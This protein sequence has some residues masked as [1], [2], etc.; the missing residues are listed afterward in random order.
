MSL[1][2]FGKQ[3]KNGPN[4]KK[5]FLIFLCVEFNFGHF[6]LKNTQNCEFYAIFSEL[7]QKM[8]KVAIHSLNLT[9]KVENF[10][11]FLK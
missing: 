2:P 6:P 11:F 5:F 8:K 1:E 3:A 9:K 10:F 7:G 4:A